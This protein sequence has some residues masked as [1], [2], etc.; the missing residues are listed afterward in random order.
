MLVHFLAVSG[1]QHLNKASFQTLLYIIINFTAPLH[2]ALQKENVT[3]SITALSSYA[4]HGYAEC[5]WHSVLML[6]M[7]ML[8]V[9]YSECRNI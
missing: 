2:S 8:S 1:S 5:R 4:E 3:L 6:S 9:V 7:D